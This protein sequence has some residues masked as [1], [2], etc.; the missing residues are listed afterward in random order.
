MALGEIY[1]PKGLA[2]ET[3]KAVLDL[4]RP[5]ACNVALGCTNMCEDCYGP[6]CF[7]KSDWG[8][9][10]KPSAPPRN[11]VLRQLYKMERKG[12][13]LP[14]GVFISFGTDPL[15]PVNQVETADLAN[16]L[17]DFGI[18]VAVLSK[19]GSL[20]K[21]PKVFHGAT[22]VSLSKRYKQLY[23][24]RAAD[25]GHRIKALRDAH[26]RGEY[27]WI[28]ME[29]YPT[30]SVYDQDLIEILEAV[31]FVDLIIFGKRNY[32]TRTSGP[33]ARSFYKLTVNKFRDYC[34]SH[35]IRYHI[36]SDTLKFTGM[37]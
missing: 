28:S 30:P 26:A 22:I 4:E 18:K 31:T 3:A 15:L 36:K 6:A 19:M 2:L 35:D 9:I 10:R 20:S 7:K 29:P 33:D 23:E 13:S 24:A 25:I 34:S 32:D 12:V 11:L 14:E 8:T 21:A 17:F 16:L 1:E 27:T 5:W 37:K